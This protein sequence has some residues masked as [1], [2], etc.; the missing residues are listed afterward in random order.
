MVVYRSDNQGERERKLTNLCGRT[1][2]KCLSAQTTAI[3]VC[4]AYLTN[5]ILGI[6]P[7]MMKQNQ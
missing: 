1:I 5:C 2:K 6:M 7:S 3:K 4:W